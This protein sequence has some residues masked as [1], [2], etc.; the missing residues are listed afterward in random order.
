MNLG[1]ASHDWT[2]E[3]CALEVF[4]ENAFIATYYEARGG[5]GG[6][7]V[8]QRD[9]APRKTIPA[10]EVMRRFKQQILAERPYLSARLVR[11]PRPRCGGCNFIAAWP[12]DAIPYPHFAEGL[13]SA[14]GGSRL[15]VRPAPV[16]AGGVRNMMLSF[17]FIR[18]TR[19][20]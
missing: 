3:Q 2:P 13:T 16:R 12:A 5:G 17:N 9:D 8:V 19:I 18:H 6:P 4:A 1:M 7:I 20:Q 15:R 10:E 11:L 14:P